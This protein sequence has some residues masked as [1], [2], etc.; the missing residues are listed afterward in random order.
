M[1]ISFIAAFIFSYVGSMPPGAI[2]ISVGQLSILGKFSQA[3]RFALAS[4]LVE[5]PYT[6]IAVFFSEWILDSE[7]VTSNIKLIAALVL[8]V[9]AAINFVSYFRKNTAKSH[10]T[11]S[12]F[13]Y[14]LIISIFNPLA[15]PFWIGVTAYLTEMGWIRL[16]SMTYVCT[17][18]LG[19]SFGTFALLGSIILIIKKLKINMGDSNLAKL[20]PAIIFLILGIYTLVKLVA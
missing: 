9:L 12:G 11:K 2:N 3:W 14:G 15:I 18:A 1:I 16:N 13:K 10:Q 5:F 20:I 8:F 6:I 4:A 19:V 17:Y 7:Y